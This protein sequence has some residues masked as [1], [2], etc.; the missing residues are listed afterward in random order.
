MAMGKSK[1]FAPLF[2]HILVY[3]GILFLGFL[4]ISGLL[5]AGQFALANGVIHLV[6]DF[7]TSKASAYFFQ[8]KNLGMGFKVV[9][10]D[11]F[12][13]AATLILTMGML[14]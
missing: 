4:P 3:S 13:H 11:Q 2:V 6:I 12:L 1:K 8:K 14:V 9:G 10:F 5:A 7:L